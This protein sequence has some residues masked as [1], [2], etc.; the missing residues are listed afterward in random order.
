MPIFKDVFISYGRKESLDFATRLFHALEAEGF[1]TWFDHVNIPKGDDFQQRIDNGIESAHNF[2]YII[3]P[4]ANQSPYCLKEIELALQ[5]RKRIIPILH[6]ER[7]LH[8]VHP[9]IGKINWIYGREQAQTETPLSEWQAIDA[10]EGV[11]EEVKSILLTDR[12]Y[13]QKHTEILREAL[14]WTRKKRATTE[15]LIGKERQAAQEWLLTEFTPPKQPPCKPTDLHCEFI[16]ESRKNAENLMSDCFICY[17]TADRSIR[18]A[19]TLSLSRYAITCWLHDKDVQKGRSFEQAIQEGIEQADNFLFF[20]SGNSLNSN[21]CLQELA[22]AL[23]WNKRIIPVLVEEL[24]TN[25]LPPSIAHLQYVD[26]TDNVREGDFDRDIDEIINLLRQDREY[27]NQHKILL[28]RAIRWKQNPKSSFL[29]RGFNL[30]NAETWLRLNASR[31]MH[32]PT[33]LHKEFIESSIAVKGQLGTEV[34]ISYSRVDSDFARKLNKRLQEIGKTTWFDQESI[35]TGAD[36]Q[37]EIYKGIAASDNFLFIISPEAVESPFCQDEVRYAASLNK[38]FITVLWRETSPQEIPDKLAAV[39]WLDFLHQPFEKNFNTLVQTLEIDREYAHSHTLWQQRASEWESQQKSSDFLLN[40]TACQNAENWLK[41]GFRLSDIDDFG[42]LNEIEPAKHPFPTPLQIEYIQQSSQAVAAAAERERLIQYQLKQRLRR[43]TIALVA[44]VVLLIVSVYFIVLANRNAKQAQSSANK[45]LA[46]NLAF[47][48]KKVLARDPNRALQMATHAFKMAE[49]PSPVILQAVAEAYYT[50]F[51]SGHPF[52]TWE[53]REPNTIQQFAYHETDSMLALLVVAEKEDHPDSLVVYR[54]NTNPNQEKPWSLYQKSILP[55]QEE[56]AFIAEQ[57]ILLITKPKPHAVHYLAEDSIRTV[58]LEDTT[59]LLTWQLFDNGKKLMSFN[60]EGSIQLMDLQSGRVLRKVRNMLNRSKQEG[61]FMEELQRLN[62]QKKQLRERETELLA[63]IAK[64]DTRLEQ[65]SARRDSFD[66]PVQQQII[67]RPITQKT[68]ELN[69]DLLKKQQVK[70]QRELEDVRKRIS[71][72]DRRTTQLGQKVFSDRNTLFD[73]SISNDGTRLLARYN[74]SGQLIDT[75]SGKVVREINDNLISLVFSPNNRLF[76]AVDNRGKAIVYDAQTGKVVSRLRGDVAASQNIFIPN[77]SLI[78]SFFTDGQGF[79]WNYQSGNIIKRFALPTNGTFRDAPL[80]SPKGQVVVIPNGSEVWVVGI[81]PDEQPYRLVSVEN[82]VHDLRFSRSGE[83]LAVE[84]QDI[85]ITYQYTENG[86][87]RAV[88]LPYPVRNLL[89]VKN[90]EAIMGRLEDIRED[91]VREWPITFQVLQKFHGIACDGFS[92]DGSYGF[93]LSGDTVQI[94]P[95]EASQPIR[96]LT[97]D[98]ASLLPWVRFQSDDNL[99]FT[100]TSQGKI[101]IWQTDGT[102]KCSI[103]TETQ[104]LHETA[105]FSPKGKYFVLP[106]A[107]GFTV[108]N[109]PNQAKQAEVSTNAALQKIVVSPDGRFVVGL[110]EGNLQGW[111]LETGEL[112]LNIA[113]GL[114]PVSNFVIHPSNSA[115]VTVHSEEA[116]LRIW[117]RNTDARTREN[118]TRK[119]EIPEAFP[120]IADKSNVTAL[121]LLREVRLP[122][123]KVVG[124]SFSP[125]GKLL[126]V[127][128]QD[129]TLVGEVFGSKQWRFRLPNQFSSAFSESVQLA[130]SPNNNYLLVAEESDVL[131]N[132]GYELLFWDLKTGELIFRQRLGKQKGIVSEVG[133]FPSAEAIRAGAYWLPTPEGIVRW[134]EQQPFSLRIVSEKQNVQ[135]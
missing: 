37:K 6:V 23:K 77:S 29:L 84:H 115:L 78:L 66:T 69:D 4:H 73:A 91:L 131:Q 58:A 39:Q 53:F 134:A 92:P 103:A 82:T 3:A 96:T 20:I 90:D 74:S 52:Y 68:L 31:Q 85:T 13:V 104:N 93:T 54:R 123:Y 42:S 25:T 110:S 14:E 75:Q 11:V 24:G 105:L 114:T 128:G 21:Y 33:T 51:S 116:L 81:K 70:A 122:F 67:Q 87:Q 59:T 126:A 124:L 41:E 109:I 16:C 19:V 65:R 10:F 61:Q 12:P 80:V 125:S 95:K 15:L 57:N 107:S 83:I 135:F 79:F 22:H 113:T 102:L 130:F 9:E 18:D 56:A 46:T 119:G 117:T 47:Q 36:F 132:V 98:R 111:H 127:A 27:Y 112:L 99:I 118:A 35:A 101:F 86:F 106:Q 34:F 129:E 133:I 94:I 44:A 108:W 30:E 40:A 64:V 71:A 17:D 60:Q 89:F 97:H 62:Q 49:S 72:I 38:R 76:L 8:A 48:S 50:P 43:G 28:S 1:P 88:Y 120:S 5:L 26:F 55:P 121:S 2:I 32:P 45:V 63:A 7:E 100:A